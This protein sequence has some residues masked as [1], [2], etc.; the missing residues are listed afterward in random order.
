VSINPAPC[1]TI[2]A[3]QFNEAHN[4]YKKNA[5][6]IGKIGKTIKKYAIK[7]FKILVEKLNTNIL[8]KIA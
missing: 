7:L 6:C 5:Y 1:N 8:Q 3:K 4:C 2:K